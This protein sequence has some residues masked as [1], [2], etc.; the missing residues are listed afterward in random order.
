MMQK[1]LKDAI[2][3]IPKFFSTAKFIAI[4]SDAIISFI[5]K[6]GISIDTVIVDQSNKC[7]FRTVIQPD[8]D[9]INILPPINKFSSDIYNGTYQEHFEKVQ[10]L[11]NNLVDGM[12]VIKWLVSV[13]FGF[14]AYFFLIAN[15]YGKLFNNSQGIFQLIVIMSSLIITYFFQRY[16]VKYVFKIMFLVIKHLFKTRW[17]SAVRVLF[18]RSS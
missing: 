5:F 7:R 9:I 3:S 11:F 12:N 8:G 10:K 15:L 2:I 16:A 6:G 14:L 13:A 18:N 4:N 1:R 17:L